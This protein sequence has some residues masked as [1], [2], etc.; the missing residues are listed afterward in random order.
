MIRL[1]MVVRSEQI[2]GCRFWSAL[3]IPE[4]LRTRKLSSQL[5]DTFSIKHIPWEEN[6]HTYQL[7]QQAMGYVVSQRVF[8]VALV[9]LVEHRYALRC[10]GKSILEDSGQ[11]WDKEK[12]IPG[13]A[14]RLSGN[15]N[16]C[17]EKQSQSR[18]EQSQNQRK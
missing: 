13:K 10:K 6:S 9:S 2:G 1:R 8:W 5:F 14:K 12:P 3:E 17:R 11:L 15:T 16:C 7:T 4:R 18:K